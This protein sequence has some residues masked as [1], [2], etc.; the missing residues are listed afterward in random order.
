M[1]D[2]DGHGGGIAGNG[3]SEVLIAPMNQIIFWVWPPAALATVVIDRSHVIVDF[4]EAPGDI[5]A[6]VVHIETGHK[7]VV[8]NRT[9]KLSEFDAFDYNVLAFDEFANV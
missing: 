2:F 8:K 5:G 4:A 9:P 6:A 7:V 1:V 3:V